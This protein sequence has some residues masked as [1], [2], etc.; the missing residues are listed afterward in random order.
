MGKVGKWPH[1]SRFKLALRRS[2]K[3]QPVIATLDFDNLSGCIYF[4]LWYMRKMQLKCFQK[5]V[6]W[7]TGNGICN[8][9]PFH[10]DEQ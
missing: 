8:F 9:N 4:S 6:S 3:K 5:D 1:K 10:I 2:S 7:E